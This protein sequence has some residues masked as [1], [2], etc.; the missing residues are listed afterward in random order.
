MR[1]P[2]SG[3]KKTPK[4]QIITESG[5]QSRQTVFC[6]FEYVK[7][8]RMKFIALPFP[9]CSHIE[10]SCMMGGGGGESGW[11]LTE[12]SETPSPRLTYL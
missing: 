11:Y 2:N 8:A 3:E 1:W 12:K 4:K 7:N 6:F 5:K 9:S 10:A